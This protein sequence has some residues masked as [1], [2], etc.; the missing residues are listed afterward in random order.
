MAP[1]N[2]HDLHAVA[3][4]FVAAINRGDIESLSELIAEDYVLQVFDEAPQSGRAAGIEGW[5]GYLTSFPRYLI[6]P[7]RFGGEGHIVA[8]LGHTTGSH[9]GLSDA[10]E[11]KLTLIWLADVNDGRVRR[12]TLVPD[13]EKNRARFGLG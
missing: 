1:R 10:E 6:L 3:L 7:H 9:L 8:M 4:D 2:P 11:S 12:W 13:T 5:K